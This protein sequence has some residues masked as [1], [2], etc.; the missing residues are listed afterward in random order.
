M[1]VNVLVVDDDPG[2][3]EGLCLA[4]DGEFEVRSVASGEEALAELNRLP[5]LAMVLDQ[6]MPGMSGLGL[7]RRLQGRS[8][9]GTILLSSQTDDDLTDLA[10]DAGAVGVLAKPC[11][12]GVLRRE[13]RQAA[14]ECL[15]GQLHLA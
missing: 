6:N 15:R 5:A 9:P 2:L 12:L 10:F 13:I 4:L 11:D 7:L 3:R 1:M 8:G 14:A